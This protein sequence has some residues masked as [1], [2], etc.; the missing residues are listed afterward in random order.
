MRLTP[1]ELA[2]VLDALAERPADALENERLDFKRA[3]TSARELRK[4]AVEMAVCFAN[5]GGGTL[6]VG[7]EDGRVGRAAAITGIGA[8]DITRLRREIY[9]GTDPSILVE[10]EERS[11]PEGRLLVMH[12]PRG[13][14]P[15]TT[16]A[17]L[18]LIRI[19][20]ACVPLTGRR[21]VELVGSSPEIDPSA[22][23]VDGTSVQDVDPAARAPPRPQLR[24]RARPPPIAPLSADPLDPSRSHPP[25]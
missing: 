11:E 2:T 10:L 24:A 5:Q 20:D 18:G 21:L 1:T 19:G 13:L 6:V 23:A 16:T 12:V 14:P 15:H 25:R 9:D 8:L 3:P 4:L 7:V 22:V 17:G